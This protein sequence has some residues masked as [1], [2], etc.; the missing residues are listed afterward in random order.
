MSDHGLKWLYRDLCIALLILSVCIVPGCTDDADEG[1]PPGDRVPPGD[2][3]AGITAAEIAAAQAAL[4]GAPTPALN[5][6]APLTAA[7]VAA[8]QAALNAV[9]PVNT[10]AVG[11]ASN[12][13]LTS[14]HINEAQQALASGG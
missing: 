14:T 12:T 10:L 13:P 7:Q 8:A 5:S 1:V 2:A 9:A 11:P 6:N 4:D 3:E